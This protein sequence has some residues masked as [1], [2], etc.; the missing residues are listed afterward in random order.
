MTRIKSI[1]NM[2]IALNNYTGNNFTT[3]IKLYDIVDCRKC[4]VNFTIYERVR[5]LSFF[6][7]IET[8][9]LNSIYV[10]RLPQ[11]IPMVS[12]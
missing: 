10:F 12:M 4:S 5:K 8:R 2:L 9:K 1:T 11:M 6:R 7:F 3:A